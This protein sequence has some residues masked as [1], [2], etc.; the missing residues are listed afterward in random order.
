M[1]GKK[2]KGRYKREMKFKDFVK[3][4]KTKKN[5]EDNIEDN[6]KEQTKKLKKEADRQ[7]KLK[8]KGEMPS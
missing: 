4:D 6:E 1:R 5:Y 2:Y 3:N 8:R 7:D